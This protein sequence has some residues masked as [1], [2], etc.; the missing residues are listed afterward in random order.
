MATTPEPE[1]LVAITGATGTLGRAFSRICDERGI[2]YRLTR[3]QDMDIAEPDS[4]ARY[5]D[6]VRPW[7]V[8]NT[9]G[10]VRVDDAEREREACF[11]ENADGPAHL[12]A[13]CAARGIRLVTFSSDL[14]FD[15]TRGSPYVEDDAPNPLNVYG[16]SKAEAERRVLEALPTAL[17]IRTSAFFGPWDEHNFVTV[18]LR[19]LAAGDPFVAAS[20]GTVSP[21]YVPD[22]VHGTLDLLNSGEGGLRHLANDGSVTWAEL[23]ATAARLVHLDPAGVQAQPT[24]RLGLAARRP[25][26]TTLAST[27]GTLLPSLADALERY[28]RES[29]DRWH[30]RA[31]AS[32]HA[33]R[34]PG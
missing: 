7:A 26:D 2:S 9:A 28:L 21:S 29:D 30:E 4:V 25:R 31:A 6:V 22:L 33:A 23:A 34:P 1:Q 10:Y 27:R 12:A 3:R 20:D 16:E 8:V 18:A 17:V 13:A 24:A 14:V 15:G 19:V 5:L 32:G 11:R